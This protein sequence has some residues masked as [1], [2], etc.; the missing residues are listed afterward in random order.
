MDMVK[1]IFSEYTVMRGKGLKVNETLNT[2]RPHV[3]PLP[4]TH[5]AALAQMIRDWEK[6]PVAP[7]T[8]IERYPETDWLACPHCGKKNRTDGVFCYACG[9]MLDISTYVGTK[10]FTDNLALSTEHFGPDSVLIL[11]V[12]DTDHEYEVRP[13]TSS[14]ELSIGRS[15]ATS[16]MIP[17]ID[18]GEAGAD[19]QG[20]SRLHMSINYD[21]K[22]KMLQ[23]RDLGSVNGSFVNGQILHPKEVRILRNGDEIKL[24]RLVMRADFHHPGDEV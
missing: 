9:L 14:R 12:Y 19:R 16:T 6:H 17:D 8:Q 4:K 5:R 2:L 23:I 21:A 1:E 13:Q 10:H 22:T 11:K 18:L 20:V 7:N 3:A 15:T 24:G